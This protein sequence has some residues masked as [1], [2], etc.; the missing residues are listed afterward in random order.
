MLRKFLG[1]G[2][3][4][5]LVLGVSLVEARKGKGSHDRTQMKKHQ[6]MREHKKESSERKGKRTQE[7]KRAALEKQHDR[8]LKK[9]EAQK[10]KRLTHCKGDQKCMDRAN[11]IYEKQKSQVEKQYEKR[12]KGL[13]S[14]ESR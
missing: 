14:T 2:V 8:K 4:L 7:E 12:S 10:E 13:A 11:Q 5:A 1:C 3:L 9:A 6:K